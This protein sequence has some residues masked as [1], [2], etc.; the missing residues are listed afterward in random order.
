MNQQNVKQT[1]RLHLKNFLAQCQRGHKKEFFR[2][3]FVFSKFSDVV[4]FLSLQ[5]VQNKHKGAAIHASL[6]FFPTKVPYQRD[7]ISL[8]IEGNI[9][10]TL[11]NKNNKCQKILI[12]AQGKKTWSANSSTL[13]RLHLFSKIHPLLFNKSEVKI[14]PQS[15]SQ[16]LNYLEK[17]GP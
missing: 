16:S 1:K 14:L 15:T 7:I 10:S 12:I 4:Q 17:H 3:W 5:M 13:E 2:T 6:H 9:H 8:I 11:Y